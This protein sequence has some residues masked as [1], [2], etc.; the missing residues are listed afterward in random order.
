MRIKGLVRGKTV[1]IEGFMLHLLKRREEFLDVT[2]ENSC[3]F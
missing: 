3:I 2:G 1:L